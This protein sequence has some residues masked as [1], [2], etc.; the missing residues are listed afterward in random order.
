MS[1]GL[2][3]EGWEKAG[4]DRERVGVWWGVLIRSGGRDGGKREGRG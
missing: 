1:D 4:G 3:R 2:G